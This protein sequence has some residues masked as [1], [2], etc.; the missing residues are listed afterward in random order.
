MTRRKRQ[1]ERQK[2]IGWIG[3]TTTLHVQHALLY[4]SLP[5]LHDYDVKM[6]GFAF[7]AGREQVTTR[8]SYSFWT[9]LW[10]LRIHL[11]KISLA[12]DKLSELEKY[13]DRDDRMTTASA[14]FRENDTGSRSRT[15]F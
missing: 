1:R 15:T 4:I 9:W 8:F 12:F 5:S 11:H 14:F 6:S 10:F 3:K 2:S 13:R 7:Y